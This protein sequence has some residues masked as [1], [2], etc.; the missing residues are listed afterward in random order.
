MG[1]YTKIYSGENVNYRIIM[2]LKM[3]CISRCLRLWITGSGLLTMTIVRPIE[4]A[5][6]NT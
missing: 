6:A 1:F 3:A 2:I 4:E 5:S